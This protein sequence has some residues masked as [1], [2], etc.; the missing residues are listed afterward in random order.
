MQKSIHFQG[1]DWAW[2]WGWAWGW[3]WGWHWGWNWVRGLGL[4]NTFALGKCVHEHLQVLVSKHVC[5]LQMC[6]W[7]SSKSYIF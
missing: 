5:H 1:W 3:N 7:A 4:V 6:T 2:G